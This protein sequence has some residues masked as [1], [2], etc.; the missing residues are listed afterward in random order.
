MKKLLSLNFYLLLIGLLSGQSM[1]V[2]EYSADFYLRPE[3]YVD[4]VEN[5]KVV[6]NQPRHGI[7]RD[8]VTD[9]E[10]LTEE[11]KREKRKIIISDLKIPGHKFTATS[12]MMMRYKNTLE[13]K[14]GDPDKMV[15]GDQ[16]YRLEYRVENAFIFTDSLVQFYWNVKSSGWPADFENIKFRVHV[17]AGANLSPENCFVYS[18]YSDQDKMST[19]FEYIYDKDVFAAESVPSYISREGQSVTVLVKLPKSMIAEIDYSIPWWRKYSWIGLLLLLWGGIR[20]IWKLVGRNE[21]VIPITSYYP[22]EGMDSALAGYLIDDTAD[23]RD[24]VSLIPRWASMG[25]LTIRE[26]PKKGIFGSSDMELTRLSFLPAGSAD[27]EYEIYKT[28]FENGNTV[29][30]SSLKNSFYTTMSRA[31]KKL[32]TASAVYYDKNANR[33]R[34]A[35]GCLGML[36]SLIAA[37]VFFAFWGILAA[38][39]ALV[40]LL[41]LFGAF[42]KK[43]KNPKGNRNYAELLGFR[44]FIKLAEVNRIKTLLKEDPKY[45]EKTMSYA[46]AFGL[47]KEWAG[48]FEGLDMQPPEWYSGYAGGYTMNNFANSL[49]SGLS[50]AQSNMVSAP[51]SSSSGGGGGSSGGGFGGGGGG[52]W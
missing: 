7:F 3:G 24:L 46:V 6:F 22:P 30:I 23:N 47:L 38:V 32:L 33:A 42:F 28:L 29:L 19:S 20:G 12:K 8:I 50:R 13:L 21:K 39:V 18:G 31:K 40:F 35:V 5:Y 52:S 34:Q 10:F 9:Y 45:F 48:K 1:D 51:S 15:F 11:G 37:G 43:R 14:I 4:V 17:P 44:Q 27:Y 26:I 49:G 2:K 36:F 25:H 41:I 16:D